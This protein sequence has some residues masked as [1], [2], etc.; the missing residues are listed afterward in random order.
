MGNLV[1]LKKISITV[2]FIGICYLWKYVVNV[3]VM[4]NTLNASLIV[5]ACS[6]PIAVGI[7]SVGIW[8][9]LQDRNV[10]WLFF[11]LLFCLT[12]VLSV[13]S[14]VREGAYIAELAPM[15]MI[16]AGLAL[17]AG[18]IRENSLQGIRLGGA[19][20]AIMSLALLLTPT[21]AMRLYVSGYD[22]PTNAVR[23]HFDLDHAHSQQGQGGQKSFVTADPAI[24]EPG[25]INQG[26]GIKQ[27]AYLNIQVQ[28]VGIFYL[29][30]ENYW[31]RAG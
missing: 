29:P 21:T 24:V 12:A 18:I 25:V 20:T 9:Y 7:V 14:V 6:T 16:L 26:Y 23:T 10:N 13:P 22:Y 27:M 19:V 31:W 4:A 15:I 8:R 30:H 5:M 1:W 2:A 17:S 11:T 3:G 28:H